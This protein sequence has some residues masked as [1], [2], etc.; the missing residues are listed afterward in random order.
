MNLRFFEVTMK[1]SEL[2]NHCSL[3]EA[4]LSA[5]AALCSL[6][7]PSEG[8]TE[9]TDEEACALGV[10]LFLEDAG[11]LEGELAAYF[12]SDDATRRCILRRL[13]AALLEQAHT[14]QKRIDKVD[15]LLRKLETK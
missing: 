2:A 5:L 1:I 7:T 9:L 6:G 4:R 15:W 8:G 3:A 14:A 10:A 13:R 12:S 11:L